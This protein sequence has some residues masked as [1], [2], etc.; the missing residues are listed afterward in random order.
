M[1]HFALYFSTDGGPQPLEAPPPGSSRACN[2]AVRHRQ[3]TDHYRPRSR[4]VEL[5]SSIKVALSYWSVQYCPH[6]PP[7]PLGRRPHGQ[8]SSTTCTQL[9]CKCVRGGRRYGLRNHEILRPPSLQYGTPQWCVSSHIN[10]D[11]HQITTPAP[12]KARQWALPIPVLILH[13]N[14]QFCRP[15]FL[16]GLVLTSRTPASAVN[17]SPSPAPLLSRNFPSGTPGPANLR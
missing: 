5:P 3:N 14:P 12:G 11:P 1:I 8:D 9:V 16:Y 7:W 6:G 2:H 15:P 17:P 10:T 4:H 13:N